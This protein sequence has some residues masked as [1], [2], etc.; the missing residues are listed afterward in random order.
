MRSL[1][2]DYGCFEGDRLLFKGDG[3]EPLGKC[4]KPHGLMVHDVLIHDGS[5]FEVQP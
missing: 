1:I 5:D 2:D 3:G 4:R